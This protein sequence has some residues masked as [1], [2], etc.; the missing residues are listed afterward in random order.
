VDISVV[1]VGKL[2]PY[3]RQ[4]VDDYARR[5]RRYVTFREHEVREASRAPTVAA[6]RAEE[7]QRLGTRIPPDSVLV[8]LTRDGASW[9][10]NDL[11]GQLN[12]WL[13]GARPVTLAIGGSQGLDSSI[14]TRAASR[15]SLGPLTLPHELARVV[16]VEQLYRAFTILRGDPY[17]KGSRV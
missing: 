12:R 2:R 15:W 17:H 7:A 16:V 8:A 14:L 4:A 11:A 3:Y 13:L 6:Q 10:S 1:A 5:L 9:N